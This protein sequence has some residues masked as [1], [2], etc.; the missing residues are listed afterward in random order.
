MAEET[1]RFGGIGPKPADIPPEPT[2]RGPLAPPATQP[3]AT[4]ATA[5][6]A[7]EPQA[8]PIDFSTIAHMAGR[9]PS[10]LAGIVRDF[11]SNPKELA[12][13]ALAGP[14]AVALPFENEALKSVPI[15][16]TLLGKAEQIGVSPEVAQAKAAKS[17][18][19]RENFL[20]NLSRWAY[21]PTDWEK[22]RAADVQAE[23]PGQ[24]EATK[25]NTWDEAFAAHAMTGLLGPLA[26]MTQTPQQT[27]RVLA[28]QKNNPAASA[29]GQ[30][31]GFIGGLIIGGK[32]MQALMD[33]VPLLKT[34]IGAMSGKL[35][36]AA[37]ALET[38]AKAGVPAGVTNLA[39]LPPAI[40]S[41]FKTVATLRSMAENFRTVAPYMAGE[42][43]LEQIT[44]PKPG[45]SR[46][47]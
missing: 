17:Q 40:A 2:D 47:T 13:G 19:F 31:S 37:V 29:A 34:T 45:A 6:P 4:A 33:N 21:T 39:D 32:G 12:A 25:K 7:P 3:E 26:D 22:Q 28:L 42:Q 46:Q 18:A 8:P 1:A 14:V 41:K 23:L 44:G 5:Q 36:E 27:A 43:T 9:I 10:S 20:G 16:G 35:D 30:I 11:Y 24:V 38:E 15:I